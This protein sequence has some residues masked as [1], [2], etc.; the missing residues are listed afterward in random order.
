MVASPCDVQEK[1]NAGA[2]ILSVHL[3]AKWQN[4]Q[5]SSY[6]T[7]HVNIMPMSK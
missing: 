3:T 1:L 7:L 4:Q 2:Q 6:V 5:S